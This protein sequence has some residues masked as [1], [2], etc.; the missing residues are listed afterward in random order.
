MGNVR[1]A[2]LGCMLLIA[3]MA[4]VLAGCASYPA[5]MILDP[6]RFENDALRVEWAVGLNFFRVKLTNLTDAQI[7]LDLANSAIVSVDGEART[8]ALSVRKDAAM[9]PPKS[10]IV[11][12]SEKGVVYGTDIL[13][14]FNAETEDRYPMPLDTNADDRLFL[15]GHSGETLRLYLTAT[16]RGKKT[17]Y[18]VPFKIAG[19]TRVQQ[20]G[21]DTTAASQTPSPTQK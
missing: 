12:S 2:A 21:A 3:G 17:V 8:L 19:A 11:L 15:K 14:R 6:A 18:D 5:Q 10:Y 7:D 9:L 13:G 20:A 4:A 1:R 16:V